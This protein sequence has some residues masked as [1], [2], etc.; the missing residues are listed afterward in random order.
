MELKQ[1]AAQTHHSSSAESQQH[2]EKLRGKLLIGHRGALAGSLTHV[3][4]RTWLLE[5]S[6]SPTSTFRV[7]V[8]CPDLNTQLLLYWGSGAPQC[9]SL[10]PQKA[11]VS[12]V[13]LL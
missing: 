1:G 5:N 12:E 13:E 6:G 2:R 7:A 4:P 8:V 3:L 10:G 11:P 9:N